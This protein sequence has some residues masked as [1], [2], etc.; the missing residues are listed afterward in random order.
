MPSDYKIITKDFVEFIKDVEGT[1]QKGIIKGQEVF[2]P[3][4]SPEDDG[5]YTV[6]YGH[7]LKKGEEKKYPQ[8]LTQKEA[9]RLLLDDIAEATQEAKRAVGKSW[10]SLGDNEK[11]IATEMTFN[12]G[13]SKLKEGFPKFMKGLK[14][15]DY[16]IMGQEYHRK[17]EQVGERRNELFYEKF[18]KP[19]TDINEGAVPTLQPTKTKLRVAG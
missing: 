12:M 9:D 8:G 15:K 17:S 1:G 16:D 7:K 4:P 5:T 11:Q 14:K 2:M 13:P 18:L 10:D 3:Y 6:G 19:Y